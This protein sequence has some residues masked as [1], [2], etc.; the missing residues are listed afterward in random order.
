MK[1][2]AFL[3]LFLGTCTLSNCMEHIRVGKGNHKFISTVPVRSNF[4]F[5]RLPSSNF[6]LQNSSQLIASVRAQ[7]TEQNNR[8]TFSKDKS[9]IQR[10]F[11]KMLILQGQHSAR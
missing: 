11:F 8:A 6:N 1:T 5:V 3:I 9:L 2:H 10:E 7:Q 4:G